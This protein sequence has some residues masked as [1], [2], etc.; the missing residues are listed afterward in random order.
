MSELTQHE[1]I[2]VGVANGWCSPP[3]CMTHD[4]WPTTEEEDEAFNDG[5][6]ACIHIIRPYVD[7]SEKQG[8][9]R[10]FAPACWRKQPYEES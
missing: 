1:W 9:E 6:D 5:L 4:G 7:E 10:N 2:A 3:V 8:V